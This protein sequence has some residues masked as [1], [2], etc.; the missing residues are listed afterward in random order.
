MRTSIL[1]LSVFYLCM[2]KAESSV[3]QSVIEESV[4]YSDTMG[5]EKLDA[6]YF[7]K[8]CGQ[9]LKSEFLF[10]VSKL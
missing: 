6:F 1:F 8:S 2:K 9:L 4:L 3:V 5:K 10:G 7:S